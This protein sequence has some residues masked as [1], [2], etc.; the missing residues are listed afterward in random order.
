LTYWSGWQEGAI[1]SALAAVAWVDQQPRATR[2][3]R[4]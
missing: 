2:I 1:I 3:R 4:G